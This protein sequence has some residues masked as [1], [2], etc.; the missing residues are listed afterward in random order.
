MSTTKMKNIEII[1][2]YESLIRLQETE[3]KFFEKTGEKLLQGRVKISFAI[4]RNLEALRKAIKPYNDTIVGIVEEYRDVDAEK[5]ALEIEK[6]EAEKEKRKKKEISVIMRP[7]KTKEEYLKKVEELQSIE[8]E[9][10]ISTISCELFD[11]IKLDSFEL[12]PLT[13]MIE[14]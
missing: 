9:L 6:K 4:N 12:E 2:N 13:F 8:V 7:G 10:N 14:E 5:E 1:K 3:K 11:G